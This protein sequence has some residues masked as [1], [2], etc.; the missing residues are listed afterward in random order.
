M[1]N[2]QISRA[3]SVAVT[4]TLLTA[5]AAPQGQELPSTV[6]APGASARTDGGK[7]NKFLLYVS[8]GDG[9]VNV[10][11]YWQ[12]LLVGELI[13]FTTPE[14][15]CADANGNVYIADYGAG[16]VD[17]YAHG[18]K[19]PVRVIDTSPYKPWACA[20]NVKN[21]NLA[22]ADYSQSSYYSQGNVAV[23][24][25]AQGK[26][27]YY[28]NKALYHVNGVAYDKYGDLLA[29]GFYLYSS[30]YLYTNF[31]YLPA[32][33]TDYQE[34]QLPAPSSGS[35]Y[36]WSVQGVTWD[37]EYWLVEAYSNVYEYTINI[38]P[39]LEG[40]LSLDSD[41][42]PLAFYFADPKKEATNAAGACG[43]DEGATAV[44]FWKYPA[45]GEPYEK[46]TH[47]IDRAFGSA[48][49]IGE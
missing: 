4:I 16:A 3:L 21:G 33:S 22:V 44:C 42:G 19:S 10:Y 41:V 18:G 15:E 13:N 20:V 7:A 39:Q 17:E 28:S 27:T 38:K 48:L 49:S 25:H 46:V 11:R 29:T 9:I 40:S 35:W 30:Y 26:P 43:G 36:G 31:A 5:C 2:F 32:K 47:G 12:H 34:I 14:G 24:A 45:G 23:Y 1:R 8:N 37:G 6:T